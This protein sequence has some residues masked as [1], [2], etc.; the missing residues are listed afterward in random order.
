M[1]AQQTMM[2]GSVALQTSE[3][4]LQKAQ[5]EDVKQFAQFE[6]DEQKT[7]AE[8]LRSMMEPA[9]TASAQ[10][11]QPQLDQKH[12]AMV[13]KL[14]QAKAGD[15]VRQDVRRGPDRGPSGAAAIQEA[16]PEGNGRKP[17]DMN[18]AKLARGHIKEHIAHAQGHQAGAV[19]KQHRAGVRVAGGSSGLSSICARPV[20]R[21]RPSRVVSSQP[22]AT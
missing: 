15:A 11:A 17:R 9:G 3:V 6:A 4:A 22:A 16:Y 18:V 8:V 20:L 13:Q 21:K 12:A 5:D 1:Q 7:I 14:Q 2:L 19:T 10:P